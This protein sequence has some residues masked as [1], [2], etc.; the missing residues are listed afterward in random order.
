[1]LKFDHVS[2]IY[3]VGTFGGKELRAV[4]DVTFE[5]PDGEVVSLIGE[6]G[7]GKS[8]IGRMI[9]QLISISSGTISFDGTDIATIKPGARKEYFRKVQGV[10]QDPFSSYNPIFK[11]DPRNSWEQA[12]VTAC[13]VVR[14]G[15]W[16]YMFY[17]GFRDVDHAQIGIARSRDGIT[18]WERHSANPVIR[19]TPNGASTGPPVVA[20]KTAAI[21]IRANAA[22]PISRCATPSRSPRFHGRMWTACGG[23]HAISGM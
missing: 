13:Q 5:V 7:S 14:H 10:F 20:P 21:A 12:K 6:S 3:K 1:M 9:L 16:H 22:A 2:K 18:N 17:I 11:A 4:N 15:D 19:P 23:R 8:T